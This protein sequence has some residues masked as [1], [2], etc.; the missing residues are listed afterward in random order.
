M[1]QPS[2]PLRFS[3]NATLL[4]LTFLSTI[5][6]QVVGRLELWY[7]RRFFGGVNF[8]ILFLALSCYKHY[9]MHALWWVALLH[10]IATAVVLLLT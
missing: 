5:I 7:E 4:V 8:V 2:D 6:A 1:Q 10:V 9:G 3:L